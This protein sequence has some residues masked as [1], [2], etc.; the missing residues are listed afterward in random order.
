MDYIIVIPFAHTEDVDRFAREH[1]VK[2]YTGMYLPARG[3]DYP[4]KFLIIIE[5][6]ENPPDIITL[7]GCY[8]KTLEDVK[9][10]APHMYKNSRDPYVYWKLIDGNYIFFGANVNVPFKILK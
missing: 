10:F 1:N 8:C 5:E 6:M 3:T 2:K 4:K 7:K 9:Y